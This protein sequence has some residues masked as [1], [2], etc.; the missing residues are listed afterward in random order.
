MKKINFLLLIMVVSVVT[1]CSKDDVIDGSG[2][3][4]SEFRNLDYFTKVKSEGV[5]EVNIIQGSTQE[6]EIIAD[7]NVLR[8]VKTKV[9]NNELRL[10][11][12]KNSYKDINLIANITVTRLNGLKNSG[13]GNMYV[14]DVDEAGEFRINNSGSADIFIEGSATSFN[15]KNE[16]S[17][18]IMGY[19]FLVNDCNVDIDG[20][21]NVE[22][23]CSNN[24]TVHID[25]SGSVY[26]KGN[27]TID[28][29]ISGSGQVIDDN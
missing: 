16:G 13:A 26:Y 23:N 20:S 7:N 3:L 15:V 6:V 17:G 28:A 22:V 5:F 10:Y 14:N 2:E 11:L 25:G 18:S 21:G 1:S 29:D 8:K 4:I 24:L 27:P 12:D 9:V 19:D